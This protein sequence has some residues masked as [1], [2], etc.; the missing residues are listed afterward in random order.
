MWNGRCVTRAVVDLR[1]CLFKST[2]RKKTETQV[3][4]TKRSTCISVLFL[5]VVFLN[6]CVLKRNQNKPTSLLHYFVGKNS[7][8]HI[9]EW[10]ESVWLSSWTTATQALP[11][12]PVFPDV[13]LSS[14]I[15][16]KHSSANVV[17]LISR[18]RTSTS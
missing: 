10:N 4:R 11:V 9:E 7:E 1:M 12:L 2:A 14:R 5:H 8:W 16:K 13:Q 18:E 6:R 17:S 15:K 3:H